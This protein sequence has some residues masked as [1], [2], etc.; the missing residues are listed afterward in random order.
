MRRFVLGGLLLALAAYGGGVATAQGDVDLAFQGGPAADNRVQGAAPMDDWQ[1]RMNATH[2]GNMARLRDQAAAGEAAHR[3]R[4]Q[5]YASRN[6]AWA[7][8]QAASERNTGRFVDLIHERTTVEGG[9][10]RTFVPYGSTA[11][12][13]SYGAVIVVPEDGEGPT[14]WRKMTPTYAAPD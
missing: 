6:Q 3:A 10:V 1:P 4:Q 2:A 7:D 13:D 5:A 11:Y 14:G 12:T 8:R 9:G